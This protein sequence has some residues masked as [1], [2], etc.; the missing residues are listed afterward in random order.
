MLQQ[1]SLIS[2][3]HLC[4]SVVLMAAAVPLPSAVVLAAASL[5][6]LVLL[7]ASVALPLA[8]VATHRRHLWRT[9]CTRHR[10]VEVRSGSFCYTYVANFQRMLYV[11]SVLGTRSQLVVT[12][13]E[14]R[15]VCTSTTIVKCK[16]DTTTTVPSS[17]SPPLPPLFLLPPLS[18]PAAFRKKKTSWLISL[19]F[20]FSPLLRRRLKKE[21]EMRRGAKKHVTHGSFPHVNIIVEVLTL[22]RGAAEIAFSIEEKLDFV[23]KSSAEGSKTGMPTRRQPRRR[24]IWNG[25]RAEGLVKSVPISFLLSLPSLCMSCRR[26]DFYFYSSSSAHTAL[27][28]NSLWGKKREKKRASHFIH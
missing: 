3:A 13:E 16:H 6:V 22:V 8:P 26:K 23:G 28:K 17:P 21:R 9:V 24:N 15:R 25:W 4:F 5:P 20:F 11:L 1:T 14:W 12:E 27:E 19:L 10:K 2:S 7:L 18:T